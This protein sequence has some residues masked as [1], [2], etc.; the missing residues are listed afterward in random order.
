MSSHTVAFRTPWA[1]MVLQWLLGGYG[2]LGLVWTVHTGL[3]RRPLLSSNTLR[4]ESCQGGQVRTSCEFLHSA[5]SVLRRKLQVSA[6]TGR[7]AWGW[8]WVG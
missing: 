4:E 1:G 7:R 2:A 3:L 6:G 8:S 5:A